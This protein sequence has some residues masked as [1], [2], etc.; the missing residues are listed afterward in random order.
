MHALS[1]KPQQLCRTDLLLYLF[2]KRIT[3][4]QFHPPHAAS[5]AV[6]HAWHPRTALPPR[7]VVEAAIVVVAPCRR[8]PRLVG[9]RRHPANEP[10]GPPPRRRAQSRRLRWRWRSGRVSA[11]PQLALLLLV[12]VVVVL[13]LSGEARVA[14]HRARAVGRSRRP[15]C[16]GLRHSRCHLDEL[17]SRA[18]VREVAARDAAQLVGVAKARD[19]AQL[20]AEARWCT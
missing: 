15:R 8:C 17:H 13:L 16:L 6:C 3:P 5:V 14:L 10:F 11:W 18:Y 4:P 20:R 12:L 9:D 7:L 1:I 2:Y 19:E